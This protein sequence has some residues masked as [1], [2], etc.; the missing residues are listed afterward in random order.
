M[1]RSST[2]A[3][4]AVAGLLVAGCS[5][6]LLGPAGTSLPMLGDGVQTVADAADALDLHRSSASESA[7]SAIGA[8][9][10]MG[11]FVREVTHAE[12]MLGGNARVMRQGLRGGLW[13]TNRQFAAGG[14]HVLSSSQLV[15]RPSLGSVNDYCQGSAG[16]SSSGI[17]SLD[18]TFGWQSGALSGGARAADG[19]GFATWSAIATGESVQGQIGALRISRGGS[20][21]TC[22]MTTP[23]L[24]INGAALRYA[25]SLPISVTFH[26]GSLW[27]LSVSNAK[28][29]DG[30]RLNATTSSQRRRVYVNGV[31]ARVGTEIATFRTDA[32]G[33]GTLT[34]TSTGA[35][36]VIAD[37]IV[38]SI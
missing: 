16:Y 32:L 18:E 29:A 19:H 27:S 8:T 5:G 11:S 20:S 15:M 34:I 31:I 36:Y 6:G 3:I 17:P 25:F 1:V 14:G 9:D 23:P 37:W 33:N 4:A 28:L 26:R 22:P 21:A 13:T 12:R 2:L 35:Q 7:R 30:S 38:V 24:T 10:A